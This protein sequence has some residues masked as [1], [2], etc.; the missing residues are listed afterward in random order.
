LGKVK[1]EDVLFFIG[2]SGWS[3]HQLEDELSQNS[4]IVTELNSDKIM[5]YTREIWK[6]TLI[7]MGEKYKVWANFPE[8]P[9]AN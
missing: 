8:N 4:W 2:Y 9:G 3:P 5:S 7:D 6:H 1:P